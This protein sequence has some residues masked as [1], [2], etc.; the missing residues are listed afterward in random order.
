MTR[1]FSQLQSL[2]PGALPKI[3]TTPVILITEIQIF[4]W[5]HV[6]LK[7]ARLNSYLE[8]VFT[9]LFYVTDRQHISNHIQ[10][11]VSTSQEFIVFIVLRF[12]INR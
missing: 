12:L 8:G 9:N 2:H 6:T 11:I 1:D 5:I 4:Y 10:Q 7:A 3:K